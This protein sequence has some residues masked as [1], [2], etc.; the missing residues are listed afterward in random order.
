MVSCLLRY[1]LT[2]Q[3]YS[4]NVRLLCIASHPLLSLSLSL[5]IYIY[6]SLAGVHGRGRGGGPVEL[7]KRHQRIAFF[8]VKI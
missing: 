8:V 7:V 6:V 4:L 3:S 2:V 1:L 5:A